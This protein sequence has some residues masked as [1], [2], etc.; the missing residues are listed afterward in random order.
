M[1]RVGPILELDN[2]SIN[3][4]G[5]R[6][7]DGVSFHVAPGQ[8]T[9]LIGPNGAGKTTV[10]NIVCGLL[11]P[12]SG[13]VRF[14]GRSLRGLPPH[15]IA[16]EGIGRT[17]QDPRVFRQL[18]VLENVLLG[19]PGQPGEHLLPAVLWPRAMRTDLAQRIER[20]RAIL[21]E[22]GLLDRA[23]D[24]AGNLSYGQQRFLS[25]ARVMAMEAPLLLM[26]EPSVGLHEGE[27]RQLQQQILRLVREQ[28]RT[29]LLIEHNMDVV[30][31][32]S[33]QI[34][35]LVQGRVVAAGPPL[36][37]QRNPTLLVAY[38]GSAYTSA[39]PSPVSYPESSHGP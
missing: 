36:D 23:D 2:V 38:L 14:R 31:S 16:L 29:V 18:S 32:I 30:M 26:D 5:L 24:L 7:L 22:I 20:A 13:D 10:F 33:D 9:S 6:A 8:V 21:A 3:F 12:S 15:R 19:M 34:I 1:S 11:P 37:M 27:V 17:F 39:P 4:G 28:G 25:L 35:L